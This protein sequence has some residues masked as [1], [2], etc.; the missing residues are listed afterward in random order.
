MRSVYPVG[1]VPEARVGFEEGGLSLSLLDISA[2]HPSEISPQVRRV[3]SRGE[4]RVASHGEQRPVSPRAW[5]VASC[6]GR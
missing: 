2:C 5:R 3:T 1:V 6:G 4:Q